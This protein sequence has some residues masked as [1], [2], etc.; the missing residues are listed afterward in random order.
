MTTNN[1]GEI[2]LASVRKPLSMFLL[3]I[4]ITSLF[5]GMLSTSAFGKTDSVNIL[6]SV[7]GTQQEY[8]ANG[9]RDKISPANYLDEKQIHVYSDKIVI[10]AKDV[11][12]AGFADTK[13]MLPIIN[14]D[15]NALQIIPDCPS[16]IKLGDIVSYKSKYANGIII[17]RVVYIAEDEQGYYFILK[18]DNNPSN[19]PGK[20]RCDQIQRK[21]I[22]V[23]Y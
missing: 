2:I 22:A 10:D 1:L 20:I 16:Q 12:W 7:I 4:F 14:K 5:F 13:S 8:P 9:D 11:Q 18:G 6:G 19:D 15:S 3:G 17:H 23:L 21:L